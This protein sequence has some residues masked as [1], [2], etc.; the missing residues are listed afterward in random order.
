MLYGK[1][2]AELEEEKVR[3]NLLQKGRISIF[4]DTYD[5]IFSD[6]DPR[7]YTVRALS[8]DFL[9]ETKKAARD[10]EEGLQL[11]MMMP[12]ERR[13]PEQEVVIKKRLRE[14]FKKHAKMAE[15]AVKK[16]KRNGIYMAIG[17]VAML[18]LAAVI[19]YYLQGSF[20]SV[21]LLVLL[22][23]AG[24]FTVW[25]GLDQLYYTANEKKPEM[26]FYQ[27]MVAAEISFIS[28]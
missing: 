11:T 9:I 20:L 16:T 27:K 24:W 4:I 19:A 17:G 7:S 25:T 1:K 10:K 22:E 28:S 5:D 13:K 15:D 8:D 12:K 23:P 6:F 2:G 18:V 21:L 26:E 14:H 3:E